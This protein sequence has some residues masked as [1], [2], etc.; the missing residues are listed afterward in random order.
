MPSPDQIIETYL[1]NEIEYINTLKYVFA[2]VYTPLHTALGTRS[3]L[4]SPADLDGIFAQLSPIM[5]IA[6][7][8]LANLRRRFPLRSQRNQ[9]N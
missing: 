8:F 3:E 6:C 9:P 7:D 4:L 1:K 2:N 5:E